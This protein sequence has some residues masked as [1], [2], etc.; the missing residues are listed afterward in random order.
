M[1]HF[2]RNLLYWISFGGWVAFASLLLGY[3]SA[4]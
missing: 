4:T 1:R 3:W 2:I